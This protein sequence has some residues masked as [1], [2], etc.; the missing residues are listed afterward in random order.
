MLEVVVARVYMMRCLHAMMP[1]AVAA[2]CVGLAGVAVTRKQD[3][4]GGMLWSP[5]Q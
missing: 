4:H 5:G 1:M 3:V 2:Y